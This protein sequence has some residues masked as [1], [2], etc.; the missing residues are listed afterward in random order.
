MNFKSIIGATCACLSVF[1]IG[2]VS[3][4]TYDVTGLFT[5]YDSTNSAARNSSATGTYDDVSGAMDLSGYVDF[6]GVW[7][8]S[9]NIITTPGTYDMTHPEGIITGIEVGAGHWF[10]PLFFN[11][12]VNTNIDAVHVWDTTYNLDNSISLFS[13][14]VI[15]DIF[16]TGSGAPG[17]P[18]MS[19]PT[20]GFTYSVDLLLTPTTVP[21]PA[22]VWLFGSGL[23]GLM[24]LARRKANA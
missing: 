21:V 4:A 6:F 5:F 12:G 2:N 15:S 10:G 9:G 22:A 24:G 7:S 17:H 16:P 18:S 20:V 3:A 13:T 14:D 11:W 23:I 19:G 1:F 8:A